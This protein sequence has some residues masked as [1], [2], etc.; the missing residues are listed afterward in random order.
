MQAALFLC[1]VFAIAGV[2]PEAPVA[3]TS[4]GPVEGFKFASVDGTEANVFLGIPFAKPPV[5]DLRFEKPEKPEKWSQPLNAAKFGPSCF[6]FFLLSPDTSGFSEDCLHLNVMAPSSQADGSYPVIVWIH[7]G[8]YNA[9]SASF[10]GYQAIVNNFVSRGVVFVTIQYRLGSLGFLST[11]DTELPGNLGLW[12]QTAALEFVRENIGYFGGDSSRITIIGLSAGG[13]S[14][15]ALT[16]SPHSQGLFN[17]SIQMSG[18][19]FLEWSSSSR[20]VASTR[21]WATE[22]RCDFQDS[23]ALKQCLKTKTVEELLNAVEKI[24]TAP[25]GLLLGKFLPR[26]DGDFFPDDLET[27][28]EKA[29]KI[30][31]LIGVTEKEG[32]L[33]TL[34]PFGGSMSKTPIPSD[35][36]ESYGRDNLTSFIETAVAPR[37]LFGD[38]AEEV[39][40]KLL[41]FYANDDAA[42]G[43]DHRHWIQMYTQL[44][45]DVFFNMASMKETEM[46]TKAG[47]PLW[48]YVVNYFNPELFPEDFPD[49]GAT[50]AC[51]CPYLFNV[52]IL[53]KLPLNEGEL[54]LQ[55]AMLDSFTN[56]AKQ[57]DPSTDEFHWDQATEKSPWRHLRFRPEPVMENAV[58]EENYRLWKSLEAYDYNIITGKPRAKVADVKTEL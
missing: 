33:F 35:S 21:E 7:G 53:P 52:S 29:P 23:I 36:F 22:L 25:D 32:I 8:G 39:Q 1:L 16:L 12:D 18:S 58:F 41:N 47:W 24:G 49:K 5:G 3:H 40:Q 30:P 42:V 15:S 45:S 17:N 27:L 50:H 20:V 55:K 57:S 34:Y 46:K 11:G 10:Y 37:E 28:V 44:V 56:F 51:E 2:R 38:K 31:S 4:Y 26:L 13:A 9:G 54:K 48:F 6:P 43:K 14:T 19:V